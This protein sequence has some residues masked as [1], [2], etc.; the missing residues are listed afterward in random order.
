MSGLTTS[1][2]PTKKNSQLIQEQK[3]ELVLI[4]CDETFTCIKSFL[5]LEVSFTVPINYFVSKE[6]GVGIL[7]ISKIWCVIKIDS[8][9]TFFSLESNQ[10]I[11]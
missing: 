4:N 2:S 11:S 5:Y 10:L 7:K 9:R 8:L 1:T 3:I 6:T